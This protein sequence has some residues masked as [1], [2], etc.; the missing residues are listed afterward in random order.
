MSTTNAEGDVIRFGGCEVRRVERRLT[1]DGVMAVIGNRAFDV[2][3]VLLDHTGRVVSRD[4]LLELAW[5]GL[6]VEENNLTVQISNLRGLLGRHAIATIPGIGYRFSVPLENQA[7]VVVVRELPSRSGNVPA[8]AF[9]L[10]GRE[11]DLDEAAALV[12]TRRLVTLIGSGGI[13]KTR[14][15]QAVAR[16]MAARFEHGAWIVELAPLSDPNLLPATVAQTLGLRLSGDKPALQEIAEAMAPDSLLLVLDNCEHLVESAGRLAA[17]LLEAC[18]GVHVLATSQQPLNVAGE[19]RY[20]LSPLAVRAAGA[21]ASPDAAAVRLLVARVQALKP[22]FVLAEA[23]VWQAA[24]ICS[25]LDGLPLAI[26]LAAARVPLLGLSGVRS[27]LDDPL[28]VLTGGPASGLE[29]HRTLEETMA[30]SHSL[31]TGTERRAFRRAGVFAGSFG[32]EQA[33]LVLADDGED[34]YAVI[35]PL[36][37]LVDM[38]LVIVDSADPPRYRLLESARAYAQDKL[39]D[40]SAIGEK[41]LTRCRHAEAMDRLFRQSLDVEWLMPSQKRRACFLPDLDN[42]RAA[43]EW[44][45]QAAHA[46]ATDPGA[47]P[48]WTRDTALERH[49]GLAAGLA[50]LFADIGQ[51]A[52]G[53]RH[54]RRALSAC[55][56]GTPPR[57]EAWLQREICRLDHGA[58]AKDNLAAV[59]RAADLL[60]PLNEPQWLYKVLGRQSI[61]LTK[62]GH[63]DESDAAIAEMQ[64]LRRIGSW[65]PLS[66]WDV[67]NA[68]D[69]L[70]NDRGDY[71]LGLEIAKQERDLAKAFDDTGKMVFALMAEE[72]CT[73]SLGRYQEA[74]GLGW[75]LLEYAERKNELEHMHIYEFNLAISLAMSGEVG[76]SLALVRRCGR[77]DGRRATL[78]K[79]LELMALFAW[80]QD[81]LDLAALIL[82]RSDAEFADGDSQREPVERNVYGLVDLELD[83]ALG[84]AALAALK[85]LGAASTAELLTALTLAE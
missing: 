36:G 16:Q 72:Q 23:D 50:W 35:D 51:G 3:L 30:W 19:W 29:R 52:E 11:A 38:S 33:H 1:V 55:H 75:P 41:A 12:A 15:G 83:K 28:R 34:S 7:P 70:A 82:G 65:P 31:L 68:R 43:L 56:A 45:W 69:Y 74:V 5:P 63:Y 39:G 49:V 32:L 6:V 44:T 53:L 85:A 48:G 9:E 62:A 20:R 8:S 57:V 84:A 27:R 59:Q 58:H 14:L 54:C 13:G 40:A 10:I 81:R 76:E 21:E 4:T 60:R 80:H 42:G 79:G 2:L 61:A 37:R 18:P 71:N 78:W 26:E 22:G 25:R 17:A 77:L 67:L 47:V 73:A 64:A 24:E 46:L 66:E